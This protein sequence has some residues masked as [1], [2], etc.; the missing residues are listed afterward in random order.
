MQ[1]F[2]PGSRATFMIDF[3]VVAMAAVLPLLLFSIWQVRAHLNYALHKQMQ[4]WLAAI[5]L[6][7]VL[8]FEIEMRLVG[9]REQAVS[10]PF[11]P[12]FV[13]PVLASHI[14]IAVLTLVVW[15]ITLYSALRSFAKSFLVTPFAH[16]HRVLGW[17]SLVGMVLTAVSGWIFFYMA[18]IAS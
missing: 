17:F 5:L 12:D 15:V 4:K 10:S 14:T 6:V 9:W 16:Y 18:F 3:V 11:Y 1:G 2:I 13:M 7:A 8:L